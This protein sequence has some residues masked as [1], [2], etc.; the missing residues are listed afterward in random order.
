M[1]GE[2]PGLVAVCCSDFGSE[3]EEDGEASIDTQP[4]A[5]IASEEIPDY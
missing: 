3:R 5:L 2:D 4:E 1:I